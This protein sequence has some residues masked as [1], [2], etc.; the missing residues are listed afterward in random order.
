M[1]SVAGQCLGSLWSKS[2]VN[3]HFYV[4]NKRE[5]KRTLLEVS[6]SSFDPYD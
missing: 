6:C 2:L 4:E 5:D 1:S 3:V